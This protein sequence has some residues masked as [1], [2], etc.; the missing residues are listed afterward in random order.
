MFLQ[1][2]GRSQIDSGKKSCDDK[3]RDWSDAATNS[4]MP[5]SVEA[6]ARKEG[7]K[8]SPLG[9]SEASRSC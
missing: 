5:M 6:E 7:K 9:S 4:G 8:N 2:E 1:E 3:G